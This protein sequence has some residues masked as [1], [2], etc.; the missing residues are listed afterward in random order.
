MRR[1]RASCPI[2]R[3]TNL[4]AEIAD[5]QAQSREMV[6]KGLEL[7]KQPVPD[8]FLGRQHQPLIP[9]SDEDE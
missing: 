3:P 2:Y 7:L 9:L 5:L 4:D 6:T 8:T 1:E